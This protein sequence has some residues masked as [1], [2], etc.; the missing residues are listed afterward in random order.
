[1]LVV[2]RV[3]A[4]TLPGAVGGWLSA[5]A[6]VVADIVACGEVLPALSS[7]LTPTEYAVPQVSPLIV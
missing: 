1:M 5:Q 3:E 6:D 7:A 4:V 2:V